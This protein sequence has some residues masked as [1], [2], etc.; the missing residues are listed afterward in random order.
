MPKEV[1]DSK[2]NRKEEARFTVFLFDAANHSLLHLFHAIFRAIVD[3]IKTIQQA[4]RITVIGLIVNLMLS[5]LKFALGIVGR[6]QAVV[7][8]AVHSLSDMATD[9]LVL[10]GIRLWSAPADETHPYGHQRIETIITLIISIILASVAFGLGWAAVRRITGPQ[11]CPPLSIAMLGPLVSI[12]AKEV[13]FRR[14]RAVGKRARSSALIANAWHHRS[15]ALSSIPALVAVGVASYFPK[16]I[17]LDQIGALIVALLILKVAWNIASPAL[18]ELSERGANH[19]EVRHI[20]ALVKT[21]PGVYAAHKI[22]T[23]WFGTGIYVDLH[24]QVDGT[25]TVD[26]G[27][28]IA[29]QV[30]QKL[31][32]EGPSV[33]DVVVHIEPYNG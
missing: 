20:A 14:T 10:F 5:V 9:L 33:A 22:R 32:G 23:R 18:A 31:L 24:V 12:L 29:H 6:S 28:Q 19:E 1:R 4:R 16:W 30:Q 15:D 7:A 11:T 25:I 21:V 2:Y 8:D 17:I 3:T 27:H 13:L 26:A